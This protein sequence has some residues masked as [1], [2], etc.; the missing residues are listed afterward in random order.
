MMK[1]TLIVLNSLILLVFLAAWAPKEANDHS[2]ETN[3]V[4]GDWCSGTVVDKKYN[5]IATAN[6][7]IEPLKAIYI[8][9]KETSNGDK[10]RVVV[11]KYKS[12][13]V[14]LNK[15]D[16]E[17]NLYS[18]S[19]YSA[20]VIGYDPKSDVAI[21]RVF[22][23]SKYFNKEAHLSSKPVKIGDPVYTIGNPYGFES[24]ISRGFVS[25]AKLHFQYKGTDTDTIVFTAMI[26]P[27]SS[28]GA[29]YNDNGE[30]IGMTNWGLAGGP[31]LAS[32]A[33][34]IRRL[35]V[36]LRYWDNL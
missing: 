32:P 24:V 29:L 23:K 33:E 7:C 22:D 35:I 13:V 2:N 36:K 3:L 1:K 15:F 25:K 10:I 18:Q 8:G 28:G 34:N 6:H 17:G 4:I 20:D 11:T 21:L 5:L 12:V 9:Y 16:L 26:A 30:Y 14:T 19:K 27:G 31:Y